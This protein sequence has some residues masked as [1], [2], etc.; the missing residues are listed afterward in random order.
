MPEAAPTSVVELELARRAPVET[1]LARRT[2]QHTQAWTAVYA[3]V[4]R[5]TTPTANINGTVLPP[6]HAS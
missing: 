4:I 1:K 3:A 6:Q 2:Q 5:E